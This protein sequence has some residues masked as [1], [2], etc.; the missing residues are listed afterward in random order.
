MFLPEPPTLPT[1]LRTMPKQ[2][3]K[4]I[5]K[6][7]DGMPQAEGMHDYAGNLL[8]KDEEEFQDV[9][10]YWSSWFRAIH[11]AKLSKPI[12]TEF[13]SSWAKYY[14]AEVV[15]FYLPGFSN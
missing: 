13:R 4:F 11:M 5:G 6:V 12:E 14:G 10:N 15:S 9:L 2:A 8:W 3:A 1:G 7:L